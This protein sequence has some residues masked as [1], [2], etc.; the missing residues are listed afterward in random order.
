MTTFKNE[1]EQLLQEIEETRQALHTISKHNNLLSKEMIEMSQK[2]DKLL[3]E[4]ENYV[5]AKQS[6]N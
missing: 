6:L 2:L 4:Y 1:K 5:S 3:N